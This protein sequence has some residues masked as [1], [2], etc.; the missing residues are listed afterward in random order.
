MS[1]GGDDGL[2]EEHEE[3]VN[4]EAWVIPYADLLTL[5]M[6]MFIALFA[7]SSVDIDKFKSLS[8][9]FNE[10]LGGDE[11]ATGVFEQPNGG[12]GP[13]EGDSGGQ[14]PGGGIGP[15]RQPQAGDVIKNELRE[16]QAQINEQIQQAAEQQDLKEVAEDIKEGAGAGGFGEGSLE[17]IPQ[18]DGLL[19]RVTDEEILFESGRADLRDDGARLLDII[20]AAIAPLQNR[21][22]V[23]GHTDSDPIGPD[24]EF[25]SNTYLSGAR[26]S[27]V[28]DYF[29]AHGIGGER[30]E[31]KGK[32]QYDELVPNTS[33]ENKARNR[34]VEVFIQSK[35]VEDAL[36]DAGLSPKPVINDAAPDD[37][38]LDEDIAADIGPEFDH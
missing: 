20:G 34:R 11:L 12:D 28:V 5:L 33:E 13:F 14:N 35:F 23:I 18:E 8:I 26:A 4:H 24:G 37:V 27:V 36:E 38:D 30:V 1:H 7:M 3:H 10:A 32:G 16:L 2:P 17:F 29:I 19:V 9:G 22:I 21:I 31:F 25:P 6:A 15:D